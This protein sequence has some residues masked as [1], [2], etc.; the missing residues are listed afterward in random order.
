MFLPSS[1][2]LASSNRSSSKVK[3]I[4]TLVKVSIAHAED[5]KHRDFYPSYHDWLGARKTD[6]ERERQRQREVV[7]TT[8][9][10]II[11]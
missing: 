8:K 6:R 11:V 7:S 3:K 1:I 10:S 5:W 9:V 4:I 2:I